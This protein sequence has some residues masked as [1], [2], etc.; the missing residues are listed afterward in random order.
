MFLR[1]ILRIVLV[2]NQQAIKQK[3]PGKTKAVNSYT[4]TI[5]FTMLIQ[6]LPGIPG[7]SI[8][9]YYQCHSD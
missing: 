5:F 9:L 2:I 1:D 7:F 4:S 3:R 6:R 8:C